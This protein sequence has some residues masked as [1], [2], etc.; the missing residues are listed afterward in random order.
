M[1]NEGRQVELREATA[2]DIAASKLLWHQSLF[3]KVTVFLTVAITLAYCFGA[4]AGWLMLQ[5]NAADQWRR[6]AEMNAQIVS[7]TIRSIYTFVAVDTDTTGQILRIISARPLGDDQTIL[8]TGFDPGDVLALAA[9][10]TKNE[11][12]LFQRSDTGQLL[13]LTNATGRKA[14]QLL[15][16]LDEVDG[17]EFFRGF[18]EVDGVRHYAASLPVISPDGHL[19]GSVV[20]SIGLAEDLLHS[21]Q[22]MLL[23][24]AL[25]LLAVLLITGVA[26]VLL[27]RKTFR[28]VPSLM[29]AL[30]RI[31][32]D[33]TSASTPFQNR[34]DEIGRFAVAIEKLRAAVVERETLRQAK[35]AAK[36]LEHI[37]HH[38]F[39]TGLPN[40]AFF[41]KHLDEVLEA[42]PDANA[43]FSLLLM[44][45]DRFKA[46][47]DSLGHAVGDALLVAVSERLSLLL[48]PHD[49]PARLGGDE[50]AIVQRVTKDQKLEATKLAKAL[51]QAVGRPFSILGH[52]VSV[53]ISIGIARAPQDDCSA[54]DLLKKA[55]IALYN[56][57]SS[58]RGTFCFFKEGMVMAGANRY[59]LERDLELALERKEFQLHYQPIISTKDNQL[60]GYEALIRWEHPELGQVPPTDFIPLAEDS[61]QIVKIGRWVVEQACRDARQLPQHLKI[62]VNVSAAQLHQAGFLSTVKEALMINRLEP[63]RIE[64]ELTE[65][66]SLTCEPVKAAVAEL[67]ALGVRIALDDFGTGH[68]TLVNLLQLPIDNIKIDRSFLVDLERNV[69]HQKVVATIIDLATKFGISTTAEGVEHEG[70]QAYLRQAGCLFAQGYHLGRPRPLFDG[71]ALE[72]QTLFRATA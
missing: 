49:F 8:D 14:G 31:A 12:W 38:D 56:A 44:D 51:I 47:N 1:N 17:T 48:G 50:F 34:H 16:W 61:G 15:L 28:P 6:Q 58:G 29:A 24:A 9:A 46:V 32:Q 64:I 68:S 59:A 52:D 27:V 18:L 69:D 65:S 26:V 35:E 53:G 41:N 37:A 11:I 30:N 40:R 36:Q 3:A 19:L 71:L 5:R 45:L 39:L 62:A 72:E 63:R 70:Q 25:V 23:N 10:Q 57:K 22:R 42:L 2:A 66:L 67:H 4:S 13:S 54:S 43:P 55:D 60:V 33:D 20:T 7:S 21:Q